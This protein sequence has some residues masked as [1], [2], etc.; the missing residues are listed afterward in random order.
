[1][2]KLG[3]TAELT[4]NR[5]SSLNLFLSHS[6]S[7]ENST[8]DSIQKDIVWS[9]LAFLKKTVDFPKWNVIILDFNV[10][11]LIFLKRFQ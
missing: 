10:G 3:T 11:N 4:I 5:V 8:L 1:M 6:S 2:L 7:S 9:F